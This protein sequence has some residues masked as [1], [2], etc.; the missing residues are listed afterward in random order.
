MAKQTIKVVSANVR[1]TGKGGRGGRGG[2][3]KG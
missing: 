2:T 3:R 1:R